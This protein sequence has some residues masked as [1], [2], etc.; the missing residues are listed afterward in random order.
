MPICACDAAS[1]LQIL[2]ALSAPTLEDVPW[3]EDLTRIAAA[4]RRARVDFRLTQPPP[5]W[6]GPTGRYDA[7]AIKEL[8]AEYGDTARARRDGSL[9]ARYYISGPPQMVAD[10]LALL[11]AAAVPRSDVAVETFR[12]GAAYD[13]END[14]LV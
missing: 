10:L 12:G 4:A 8:V 14:M 13:A 5:G 11:D 1:P 6:A 3:R 9:G 7:A 2:L